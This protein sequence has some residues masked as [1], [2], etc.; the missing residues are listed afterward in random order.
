MQFVVTCP[1]ITTLRCH[2]GLLSFAVHYH[3]A[4]PSS[5]VSHTQT[6]PSSHTWVLTSLLPSHLW[7][8]P[9]GKMAW[10]SG[11]DQAVPPSL[12]WAKYRVRWSSNSWRTYMVDTSQLFGLICS[13]A[14]LTSMMPS[15]QSCYNLRWLTLSD[16][17]LVWKNDLV[18]ISEHPV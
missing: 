9:R 16:G 11:W 5:D 8:E 4:F 10:I 7:E 15:R 17:I 18:H 1:P 13:R 14:W 6:R 2:F 12:H 3:L